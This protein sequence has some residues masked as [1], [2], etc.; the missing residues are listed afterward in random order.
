MEPPKITLA[1]PAQV[2]SSMIK[3]RKKYSR[4]LSSSGQKPTTRPSTSQLSSV[5]RVVSIWESQTWSASAILNSLSCNYSI[6]TGPE[7]TILFRS[8]RQHKSF[9]ET[10]NPSISTTSGV[11]ST[12]KLISY[13]LML[14][15]RE[16]LSTSSDLYYF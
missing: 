8:S 14:S 10:S 1:Q 4:T 12:H 3:I 2:T 11:S 7:T 5:S 15:G 13:L 16:T 6:N 9:Q